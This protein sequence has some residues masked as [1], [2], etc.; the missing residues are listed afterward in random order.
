MITRSC[1]IRDSPIN[2]NQ[3]QSL[4]KEKEERKMAGRKGVR[5]VWCDTKVL[6]TN[7]KL[8]NMVSFT[9]KFQA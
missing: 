8:P 3:C 5:Y 7:A 9:P 6:L 4:K 1:L 2:F